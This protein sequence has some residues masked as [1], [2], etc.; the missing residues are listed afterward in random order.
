MATVWITYAWEDNKG[1]DVDFAAQELTGAGLSVKLDRWNIQAGQRLW[2]QIENFIQNPAECDAWLLYTTQNSLGS[3]P[4]KEEFAYA[5]DRALSKRGQRFPVIGLFPGPVDN[6]LIPAAIR[7]RLYVSLTDPDWRERIKAA[8]EGRAP[9]IARTQI[10]P[11][12]I[13][14]HQI[15]T[16]AGNKY[17]IE[18]RPRAG[19]W[20]PFFAGIPVGEKSL[21]N[22]RITHAA[23][24][25]PEL[26]GMLFSYV[27][28]TSSDKVWYLI[29]AKNEATPTQSYFVHCDQLP[30]K[31]MFGVDGGQPQFLVD[32]V[33]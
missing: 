14:V 3:E 19:A 1:N 29:G 23:A 24:N 17:A 27:E 9:S 31:L 30:S 18:V 6:N 15:Q 26:A 4:C 28:A 20:S 10:N 32:P 2:E 21:V 11:Y 22:P 25:R 13:K 12:F 7:T 8:A 5:L 33:A 16:Q